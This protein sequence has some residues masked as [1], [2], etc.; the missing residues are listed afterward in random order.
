MPQTADLI[1]A[2]S[3]DWVPDDERTGKLWHQ[4]PLWF[5]GNFQYFSIPI[6]FIGPALGLSLGWSI[7]AGALGILVGT[8][9]M[10]FHASQG[11]TMGLPQ[12]IQ[13][14]AQ[15]GYRGVVVPLV[16]TLFTYLA[17][18]VVD[19][20][21]LADGLDSA[22][23]WNPTTVAVLA[24]VAAA[25]LAIFGHDWL[26]RAFR[27]LLCVSLPLMVVV[28]AGILFGAAGG[29][30]APA[31]ASFTWA[32]FLAQFSAGAAYNI[33]YAPYVSDYSRYLPARTPARKVARRCSSAP[34]ARRSG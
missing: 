4:A 17:F 31:E 19:V 15:F 2:R 20:V 29:G 12:M 9:F 33:T 16:A 7:L 1:E 3:I 18:N 6:G 13:S 21:L 10:A 28:T 14:R 11:P 30:P 34:R 24:T 32:A 23:G 26:H 25:T 5:L 27:L 22:F 8:L